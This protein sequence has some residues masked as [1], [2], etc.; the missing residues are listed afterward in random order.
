MLAY[1]FAEI[2]GLRNLY[3][4]RDGLFNKYIICTQFTHQQMHYSLASLKVLNLH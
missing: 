2:S 1:T 4:L 3:V